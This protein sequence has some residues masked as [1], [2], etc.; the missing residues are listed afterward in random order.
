[1]DDLL[2]LFDTVI[3]FWPLGVVALLTLV[4]AGWS[5]G[6]RYAHLPLA[7]VFAG[8]GA[9]LSFQLGGAERAAAYAPHGFRCGLPFVIPALALLSIGVYTFVT[10]LVLLAWRVTR[11]AG[12][13]VL[14]MALPCVVVACVGAWFAGRYVPL[15]NGAVSAGADRAAAEQRDAS[16]GPRSR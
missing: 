15:E 9:L 12:A 6:R 7:V 10:G 8:L 5:R 2:E 4:L 16:D 3:E 14:F 13:R 1:M 11:P